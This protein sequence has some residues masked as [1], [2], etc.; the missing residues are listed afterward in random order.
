M[1]ESRYQ[2][3]CAEKQTD[4]EYFLPLDAVETYTEQVPKFQFSRKYFAPPQ[5]ELASSFLIALGKF[6]PGVKI[7]PGDCP[8][9]SESLTA[10]T[11]TQQR[12]PGPVVNR[13]NQKACG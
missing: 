9:P 1:V 6:L 8:G 13:R 3:H 11:Y 4:P 12:K 2:A 5:C 7:A 10:K